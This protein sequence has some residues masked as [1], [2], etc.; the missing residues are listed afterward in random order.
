MTADAYRPR[1]PLWSQPAILWRSVRG[2]RFLSE[3]APVADAIEA[4][5]S[6]TESGWIVTCRELTYLVVNSRGK[7][8]G[9][10][11]LPTVWALPS[12]RAKHGVWRRP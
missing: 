11:L 3:T 8:I 2:R 10:D 12:E 5:L 9:G 4:A 7:A 6:D 1:G